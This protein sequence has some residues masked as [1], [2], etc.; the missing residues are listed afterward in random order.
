MKTRFHKL[1]DEAYQEA[2]EYLDQNVRTLPRDSKGDFD[3]LSNEF[4]VTM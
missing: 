1:K 2:Y 3:E 4:G